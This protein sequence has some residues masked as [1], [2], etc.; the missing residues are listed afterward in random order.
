M[1]IFNLVKIAYKALLRNKTRAMLT[2][3]GIIIGIT[4]VI[5]MVNLGQ[6]STHSINDQISSM[7]TNLITIS[8]VSQRQGGVNIG[9]GDAQTLVNKDVDAILSKV[10]YVS[11]ATPVVSASGQ[12]VNGAHNWPGIIQG[13]NIDLLKIRKLG[14]AR[15]S[16]FTKQDIKSAAKVCIVGKTVVDNLFP[17]D[18]NPIG[19]NIRIDRIPLKIIGILESKGQNQ[20]GQDQ[21]DIVIAPYSTVQKRF[22]GINYIH[23]I[24]ASANSENVAILAAE[25]IESILR[26]EH[27]LKTEQENDFQVRTQQEILEMTSSITG[28]LTILLVAIASIS[29][30]VGGIGIMNI[31]YVT[32]TERTK[33]IGLRMSIG[34]QNKDILF[35]FLYESIILCLI[36]GI[37]GIIL[38]LA[39]SHIIAGA[40]SWPF[41]VSLPAVG[42]SFL[43]C[44]VT[45]IF[46]GW[47]PAKKA[48]SLDPIT[49]LRYE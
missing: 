32:V 35:Q 41:I 25:E 47:Y 11:E 29:L 10:K 28:L 40:L 27:K 48:A 38:G 39:L 44:T 13:G 18:K 31:M 34:A 45:G 49:A 21:D 20:M 3:L 14:L 26:K 9:S 24:M 37:I 8:R 17:D 2:M 1:D 7:G 5:V 42:I 15:G 33:E 46:F 16:N 22:L 12:L 43:V 6:S 36:G 19:K 23:T 30:V 4:S